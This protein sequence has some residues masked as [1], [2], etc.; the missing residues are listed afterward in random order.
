MIKDAL[1]GNARVINGGDVSVRAIN[2]LAQNDLAYFDHL[3]AQGIIT[4]LHRRLRATDTQLTKPGGGR[5]YAQIQAVDP[6]LYPL[7]GAAAAGAAPPAATS[8]R[9]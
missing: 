1:V 5:V 8:A 2:P 9:C 3:K 6:A 7:T 4:E